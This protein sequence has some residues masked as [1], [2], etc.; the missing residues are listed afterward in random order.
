MTD[1]SDAFALAKEI[2]TEIADT[3]YGIQTYGKEEANLL[4]DRCIVLHKE[5]I[6]Y[7]RFVKADSEGYYF[8]D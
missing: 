8:V 3:L 4:K 6:T 7:E 5:L 2:A 1:A